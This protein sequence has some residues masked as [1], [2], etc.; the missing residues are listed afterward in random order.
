MKNRVLFILLFICLVWISLAYAHPPQDILI[1]YDP[2]TKMLSAVIVHNTSNPLNH[3]IRQVDVALNGKEIIQ[4]KISKQDN[5]ESQQVA[6]F[7]PDAKFGD[8]LSVEGYCSISGK[9]EKE[10]TV[11]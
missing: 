4:Q 11:E 6:Y 8:R 5:N 3:Y 9:L 10:I 2:A 1:S 7:I